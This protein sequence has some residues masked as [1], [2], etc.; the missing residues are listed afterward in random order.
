M[1]LCFA[2][3]VVVTVFKCTFQS[4]RMSG[5]VVIVNA[6]TKLVSETAWKRMESPTWS[7]ESLLYFV[8]DWS[9]QLTSTRFCHEWFSISSHTVVDW[10]AFVRD[11]C[12][13]SLL[14]ILMK[15]PFLATRIRLEQS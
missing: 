1:E 4:H 2:N 3:A 5:D 14:Q 9:K 12:A 10:N 15:L 11:V 13:W 7:P 8:D 6:V